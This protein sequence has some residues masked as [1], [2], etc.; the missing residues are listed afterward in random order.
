M[1][2]IDDSPYFIAVLTP[3][4]RKEAE[5]NDEKVAPSDWTLWE[6]GYAMNTRHRKAIL[7]QQNTRIPSLLHPLKMFEF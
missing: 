4:P 1:K 6:Y 7:F 3:D 5:G 2:K